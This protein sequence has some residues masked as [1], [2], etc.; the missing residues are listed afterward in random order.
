MLFGLAG[1]GKTQLTSHLVSV[2]TNLGQRVFFVNESNLYN[3][4]KDIYNTSDK[5]TFISK[6]DYF[7]FDD[8][9]GSTNFI[10]RTFFSGFFSL[11]TILDSKR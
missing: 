7:I 5:E 6:Y 3:E 8:M 9:N 10:E 4:T 1:T 2:A 11:L